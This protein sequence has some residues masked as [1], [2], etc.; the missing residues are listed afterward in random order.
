MFTSAAVTAYR[1]RQT[2]SLAV[3]PQLARAEPARMRAIILAFGRK[4]L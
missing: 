4:L 1:E 3:T 2:E